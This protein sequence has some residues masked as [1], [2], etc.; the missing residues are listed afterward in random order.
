MEHKSVCKIL[1]V[2]SLCNIQQELT[3]DEIRKKARRRQQNKDAARRCRAKKKR[4][5]STV[6]TV[7]HQNSRQIN[8]K[9]LEDK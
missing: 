2:F 5:E 3:P 4:L 7:G 8:S 6:I 1:I 9:H